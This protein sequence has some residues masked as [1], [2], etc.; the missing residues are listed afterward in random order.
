MSNY[1]VG[2]QQIKTLNKS[3]PIHMDDVHA[4]AFLSPVD[5]SQE[6]VYLLTKWRKKYGNYFATKFEPT[7]ERT[8][9]WIKEQVIKNRDKILFLIILN[10]QKIGNIGFFNYN[11]NNNSAEI[12]NVLRGERKEYAGLMENV[13]YSMFNIGFK[14]LKLSKITLKV[15]SDN[16]KAINLYERCGMLEVKQI[17]LK[18]IITNDGWRWEESLLKKH[19]NSHRF[20]SF[21]EI[22]KTKYEKSKLK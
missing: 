20:F 13:L 10:K 18:K 15:F 22:T 8:R 16:N 1:H 12:D 14:E 19:E 9:K 5:T 2:I 6:S 3:I 11:K 21:M 17:P 7:E 4:S